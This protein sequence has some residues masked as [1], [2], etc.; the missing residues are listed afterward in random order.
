MTTAVSQYKLIDKNLT[1]DPLDMQYRM[2]D[3]TIP[4]VKFF[5]GN[6]AGYEFPITGYNDTTKQITIEQISDG[7]NSLLPTASYGFK[8]G[9]RFG[10][11]D[12]YMPATMWQKQNK[13]FLL[14]RRNFL[15][16]IVKTKYLILAMWTRFGLPTVT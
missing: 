16:N 3:G 2:A 12:L 8:L 6:L 7:T 10:F 11:V 13:D 1:F 5:T 9:D 14:R 4:K 15:K